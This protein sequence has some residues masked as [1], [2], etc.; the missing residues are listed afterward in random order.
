MVTGMFFG[1]S[2]KCGALMDIQ[3]YAMSSTAQYTQRHL[4]KVE[5][6]GSR[7]SPWALD[8]VHSPLDIFYQCGEV[9]LGISI[10]LLYQTLAFVLFK[11]PSVQRVVLMTAGCLGFE[12]AQGGML[13]IRSILSPTQS[14]KA[15]YSGHLCHALG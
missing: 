7:K 11:H 12:V 10:S 15:A 5:M 4:I 14:C 9:T 2:V 13:L 3:C 6:Q 8:T 1:C